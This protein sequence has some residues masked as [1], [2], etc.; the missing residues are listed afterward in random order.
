MGINTLIDLSGIILLWNAII[1]KINFS[2]LT[3]FIYGVDIATG[4][5]MNPNSIIF[6]ADETEKIA[7]IIH[8]DAPF[9]TPAI[10][11]VRELESLLQEYL[12]AHP[13]ASDTPVRDVLE[14]GCQYFGVTKNNRNVICLNAFHNPSRFDG[15]WEKEIISVLDGGSNYF[16][17]YYDPATREYT[18]LR[19]NGKA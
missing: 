13:P 19:Y 11:Q 9:W 2:G 18:G 14:Y 6:P 8:G 16:Q 15:R 1:K 3:Y 4:R 10:D 5:S 17:V 12:D 7:F